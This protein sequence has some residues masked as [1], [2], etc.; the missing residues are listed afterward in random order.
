MQSRPIN[1]SGTQSFHL[2]KTEDPTP[3]RLTPGPG[4]QDRS[5][6]R[7]D[8]FIFLFCAEDKGFEPS[9]QLSSGT[10][11]AVQRSKPIS[12]Y[13]PAKFHTLTLLTSLTPLTR[14]YTPLSPVRVAGFEPAPS[15]WKTVTLPLRHTRHSMWAERIRSADFLGLTK[16]SA[17]TF[18]YPGWDSNPHCSRSERGASF[19]WATWAFWVIG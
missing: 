9:S 10:A 18:L 15:V 3:T 13:P 5:P 6:L 16:L 11:L 12:A 2:R 14:S 4:F 8:C 7:C 19:R 1:R 17:H